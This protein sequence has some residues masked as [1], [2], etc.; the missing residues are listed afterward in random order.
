MAD[1]AAP[2]FVERGYVATTVDAIAAATGVSARP[3]SPRAA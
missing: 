2:L 3:S 1:A